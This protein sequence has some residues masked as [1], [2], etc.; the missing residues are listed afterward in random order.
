MP[1]LS[2]IE[3]TIEFSGLEGQRVNQ[4][5]VPM[6]SFTSNV[7]QYTGS[8]FAEWFTNYA[9]ILAAGQFPNI[10]DQIYR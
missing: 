9:Q 4:A 2:K 7:Y 1:M 10:S 5:G 3:I 6:V 8:S